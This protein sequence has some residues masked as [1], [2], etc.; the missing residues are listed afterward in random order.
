MSKNPYC[1]IKSIKHGSLWKGK[2]HW[3][4]VLKYPLISDFGD[5]EQIIWNNSY[6]DLQNQE[7]VI[8][9]LLSICRLK[10]VA[11][12]LFGQFIFLCVTT[13]Q[14][15]LFIKYSSYFFT[16]WNKN[17]RITVENKNM[18]KLLEC[19]MSCGKWGM[20]LVAIL[21]HCAE[22]HRQNGLSKPPRNGTPPICSA[23]KKIKCLL[24]NG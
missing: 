14:Y 22:E 6:E 17:M 10:S 19:R 8:F 9:I 18:G 12:S 24:Q 3:R 15:S 7:H 21:F 16:R 23:L 20:V 11:R 13:W 4:T 5:N 1:I 2:G